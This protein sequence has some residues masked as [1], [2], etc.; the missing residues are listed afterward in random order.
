[1][2]EGLITRFNKQAKATGGEHFTPHEVVRQLVL[3]PVYRESGRFKELLS[4]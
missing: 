2:I 3:P 4:K 1:M